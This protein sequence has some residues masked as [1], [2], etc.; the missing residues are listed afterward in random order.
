MDQLHVKSIYHSPFKYSHSHPCFL[1]IA[2][3]V[4]IVW[5]FLVSNWAPLSSQNKLCS[6]YTSDLENTFHQNLSTKSNVYG[7]ILKVDLIKKYIS[8]AISIFGHK[9]FVLKEK[10]QLINFHRFNK[11]FWLFPSRNQILLLL[12]FFKNSV[13]KVKCFFQ[14]E[15]KNQKKQVHLP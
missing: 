3:N 10:S 4:T 14:F 12:D 7:A 15:K 1:V 11:L 6:I 8:P 13:R 9:L 5:L 2:S